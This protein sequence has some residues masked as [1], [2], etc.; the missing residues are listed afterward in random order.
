MNYKKLGI[1]ITT[2]G[3]NGIYVR[4]CINCFLKFFPNAYI[5]LFVNESRDKITLN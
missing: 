5:V 1:V 4:N 2:H 3:N